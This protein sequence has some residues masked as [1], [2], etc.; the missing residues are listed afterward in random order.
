MSS[1]LS[2]L[3]FPADRIAEERGQR[4]PERVVIE[5][6]R[7]EFMSGGA[8]G[9]GRPRMFKNEIEAVSVFSG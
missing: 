9:V 2:F 4:F 1:A 3:F 7:A 6:A 8:D 5:F